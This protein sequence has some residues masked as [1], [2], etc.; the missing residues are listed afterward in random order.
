M[1]VL[2]E[3]KG[4]DVML[5]LVL[6]FGSIILGIIGGI[7][8]GW[9][10]VDKVLQGLLGIFI[11]AI[12]GLIL[13]FAS[14]V[15]AHLIFDTEYVYIDTKEVY[16]LQDNMNTTGQF[17]LGSGSVDSKMKYYFIV[18]EDKGMNMQSVDAKE[19]YVNEIDNA[20]PNVNHYQQQFKN[21]TVQWLTPA[22]PSDEYIFEIPTDSIIQ[23]YN[24]DLQ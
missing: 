2:Y 14:L 9:G 11:G 5:H 22:W 1:S 4:G 21:K 16:A 17:F 12:I 6:F 15:I 3:K 18:K 19:S 8:S 23:N 7:V 10:A 13:M 24:I 20:K